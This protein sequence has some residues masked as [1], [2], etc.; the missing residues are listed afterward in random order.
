MLKCRG[1]SDIPSKL[2]SMQNIDDNNHTTPSWDQILLA[3]LPFTSWTP[4][5]RS[6]MTPLLRQNPQV[7]AQRA[8]CFVSSKCP[9]RDRCSFCTQNQTAV[10]CPKQALPLLNLNFSD[11]TVGTSCGPT[12][13]AGVQLYIDPNVP[14]RTLLGYH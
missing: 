10:Y 6:I 13:W 5:N 8:G 9:C 14:T 1:Y 3:S 2:F 4:Q 12:Y 11:L 7:I